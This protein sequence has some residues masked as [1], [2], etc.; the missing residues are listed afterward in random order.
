MNDEVNALAFNG[1][2]LFVGGGF[3]NAGGVSANYIAKW[4]G[5]AWSALGLGMDAP[6]RALAATASNLYAAGSFTNAVHFR[7]IHRAMDIKR[8]AELGLRN[9]QYRQCPGSQRRQSLRRRKLHGS[10][11]RCRQLCRQVGRKSLV[12]ARLRSGPIFRRKRPGVDD[13][14]NRRLRRRRIH[15][16]RRRHLNRVAKWDGDTW[17]AL[18]SGMN[19]AVY[20]LTST[21]DS[22][23]AGGVFT[24]ADGVVADPNR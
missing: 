4:D 6:V 22:L 5:N 8:L 7:S 23:F 10:G 17:S 16:Q 12:C 9:E 20:A 3:T 19:N 18:G 1:G 15:E 24:S 14:R 21:G 13:P 11:R 2:D